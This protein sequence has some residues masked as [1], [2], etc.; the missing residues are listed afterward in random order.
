MRGLTRLMSSLL[1]GLTGRPRHLR[2][3]GHVLPSMARYPCP[4]L[5]RSGVEILGVIE[6]AVTKPVS[7]LTSAQQRRIGQIPLFPALTSARLISDKREVGSSS[8]PRPISE[9]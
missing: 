9:S 3:G 8:L 1:Y 4:G 5:V 7:S 6:K 2:Q